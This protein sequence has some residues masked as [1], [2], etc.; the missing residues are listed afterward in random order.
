MIDPPSLF[1]LRRGRPG[2][3]LR[4]TKGRP[5]FAKASVFAKA[6]PRQD[7]G[8]SAETSA[9]ADRSRGAKAQSDRHKTQDKNIVEC[10]SCYIVNPLCR[11]GCEGRI[12]EH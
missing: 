7:A 3:A 9:A 8:A 12:G 2:F 10:R 4:A 1:E 5:G 6:T 11:G